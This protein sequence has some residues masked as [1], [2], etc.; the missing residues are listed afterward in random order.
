M[1]PQHGPGLL[2]ATS[3]VILAASRREPLRDQC[4]VA[5]KL[6]S[7]P[8]RGEVIGHNCTPRIVKESGYKAAAG[9]TVSVNFNLESVVYT[10]SKSLLT[11][12]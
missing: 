6:V 2:P 10:Q 7:Y 3:V 1:E 11:Y 12:P 5:A 4:Q 8:D 9:P